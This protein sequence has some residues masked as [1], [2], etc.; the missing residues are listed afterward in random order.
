[1]ATPVYDVG[2]VV[3]LEILVRANTTSMA[4]AAAAGATTITVYDTTGYAD[5]NVIVINPS[6]TPEHAPQETRIVSGAPTATVITLTV[7]LAFAHPAG[8]IVSELSAGTVTAIVRLPD[9]TTSAGSVSNVSTGRYRVDHTATLAGEHRIEW[10]VASPA[11]S[12]T[13]AFQVTSDTV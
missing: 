4:A 2:D 1:M 9:G 6:T 3:R 8:T 7:A 11:A 10:T 13:Y 12:G 5:T